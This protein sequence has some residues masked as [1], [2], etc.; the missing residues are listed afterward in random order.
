MPRHSNILV[1]PPDHARL[2]AEISGQISRAR[3]L[4]TA[5]SSS[6][7]GLGPALRADCVGVFLAV[8]PARLRLVAG[9]GWRPGW[10]GTS[11]ERFV[12]PTGAPRRGLFDAHALRA[13]AEVEIE[14]VAG[15]PLGV[16]GVYRAAPERFHREDVLLLRIVADLLS[17]FELSRAQ[18]TAFARGGSGE[19][20]G[21]SGE[22]PAVLVV[23]PDPI[24][25]RALGVL[26]ERAGCRVL[27]ARSVREALRAVH[28]VH[29]TVAVLAIELPNAGRSRLLTTLRE[30]DADTELVALTARPLARGGEGFTRALGKPLEIDRLLAWIRRR[31]ALGRRSGRTHSS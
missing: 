25:G 26:L 4:R 22:I 27:L 28:G 3:D 12:P 6:V 31:D 2:A 11:T 20:G 15:R 10:V 16:L 9:S 8:P 21:G 7:Y 17:L 14:G 30:Q 23:D 24:A 18:R 29:P 5:A 13:S 19:V 1:R